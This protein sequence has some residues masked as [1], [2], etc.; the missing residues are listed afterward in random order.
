[1]VGITPAS[2]ARARREYRGNPYELTIDKKLVNAWM[3]SYQ[4][5]AATMSSKCRAV[6]SK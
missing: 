1:M 5:F 2:V 6:A 4:Q 3:E